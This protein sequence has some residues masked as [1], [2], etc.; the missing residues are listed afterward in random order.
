MRVWHISM[1]C[2][3]NITRM[4]F[5][6]TYLEQNGKVEPILIHSETSIK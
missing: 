6:G 1:R 2:G 5:A 3:V 4:V